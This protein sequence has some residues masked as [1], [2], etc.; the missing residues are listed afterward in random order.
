M[1][2]KAV[3]KLD[4][5]E[6]TLYKETYHKLIDKMKDRGYIEEGIIGI[7]SIARFCKPGTAKKK[8]EKTRYICIGELKND[9]LDLNELE[10]SMLVDNGYLHFGGEIIKN[11]S[12][13]RCTIYTD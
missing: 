12:Q 1:I 13:F 8:I 4:R 5:N 7:P 3:T 2:L 11:G 9:L 10:I 6:S